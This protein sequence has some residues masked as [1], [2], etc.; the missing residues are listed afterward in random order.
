MKKLLLVMPHPDDESFTCGGTVAKYVKAGWDVQLVCAT[1]GEAGSRG[2]H[3]GTTEP[4]GDIRQRELEQA[5]T[6]LGLSSITFLGYKDGTLPDQEPGEM[7]E[8]IFRFMVSFAPDVTITL[9]PGGITNHPDHI[10]FT[11]VAR[12]AFQEYAKSIEEVKKKEISLAN[13]PR[14]ARD[15]WQID[16]A[17]ATQTKDEPKLYYA[18]I[19]E[20][21]GL[22]LLKKKALPLQS[23]GNPWSLIPDKHITTV[24]DVRKFT[25]VKIKALRAHE[26]QLVDVGRFLAMPGQVLAKYEYFILR[27]QGTR[28]VYMGKD[29]RVSNRL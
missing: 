14:H 22:H 26:S 27:M 19:P 10:K 24:I 13:R 25:S 16:L 3:E 2:P 20:S 12:Y 4:L 6:M 7:E 11:R 29:D 9:E 15:V 5:G 8:K 18:C 21:V 23:F 28:E 17:T 1:R